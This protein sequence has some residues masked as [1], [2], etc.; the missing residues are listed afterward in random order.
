M[1]KLM[2]LMVALGLMLGASSAFAQD[3]KKKDDGEKKM[4][5]KGKKKKDGEGEKKQ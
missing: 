2:S 5:K 4:K 1:K 3:E